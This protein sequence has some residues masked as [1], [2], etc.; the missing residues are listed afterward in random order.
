MPKKAQPSGFA[1]KLKEL[2]KAAGLT[3]RELAGQIGYHRFS[4]AKLEQGIQEPTWPTVLAIAG[5]LGRK[6]DDFVV[7]RSR[8][9]PR[10]ERLPA[11]PHQKD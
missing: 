9:K 2:R 1:E 10:R 11:V 5:A 7:P 4:I 6:V 3:Q 8:S